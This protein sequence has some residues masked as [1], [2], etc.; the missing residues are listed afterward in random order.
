EETAAA[1]EPPQE[2]ALRF[3]EGAPRFRSLH[4][5]L[6]CQLDVGVQY[7]A[8]DA[9]GV[10][11]AQRHQIPHGDLRSA[12]RPQAQ[13]RPAE[14]R[15]GGAEKE[16]EYPGV[17]ARAERRRDRRAD[18]DQ[19]G[20]PGRF[21]GGLRE[22]EISAH[23]VPDQHRRLA[24][25]ALEKSTEEL[26]VG[27]DAGGPAC[28]RGPAEA[29]EIEGDDAAL[30]RKARSDREP[31]EMGAAQ[32]VHEHDRTTRSAEISVVDGAVEIDRAVLHHG[33]YSHGA[34]PAG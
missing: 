33:R 30:L 19:R 20:Y 21:G 26:P 16:G 34:A 3:E 28:R 27:A 18:Q 24:S 31:V 15:Q 9:R 14:E 4:R 1:D 5:P 8:A 17:D 6:S 11:A 10:D 7:L 22:G 32:A 12:D 23:G 29:G 13:E 25:D 2:R